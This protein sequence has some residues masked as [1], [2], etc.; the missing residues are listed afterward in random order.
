M[1]KVIT[2]RRAKSIKIR[3][4]EVRR[5]NDNHNVLILEAMHA[6][7][8][9]VHVIDNKMRLRRED[10]VLALFHKVQVPLQH[11]QDGPQRVPQFGGDKDAVNEKQQRILIRKEDFL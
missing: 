4:G 5:R 1:M 10:G 7:V 8:K 3:G 6:H 9:N 2:N 11:G